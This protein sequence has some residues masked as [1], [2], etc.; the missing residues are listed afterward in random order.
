MTNKTGGKTKKLFWKDKRFWVGLV[1]VLFI[2]IIV[3]TIGEL[4]QESYLNIGSAVVIGIFLAVLNYK[5]RSGQRGDGNNGSPATQPEPQ[6]EEP[7]IETPSYEVLDKTEH[8]GDILIKEDVMSIPPEDFIEIARAI[9]R[10]EGLSQGASF[11]NTKEAYRANTGLILPEEN[12]ELIEQTEQVEAE[13]DQEFKPQTEVDALLNEG[14]I[15]S[16]EKD[17]FRMS[18]SSDYYKQHMGDSNKEDDWIIQ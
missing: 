5:G 11:Y 9:V 12:K 13:S 4:D 1:V 15:G 16:F 3:S 17:E 14:Y 2:F 6:F 18:P 8:T 10:E 7:I